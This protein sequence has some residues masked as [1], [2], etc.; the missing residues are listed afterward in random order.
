M[1]SKANLCLGRLI[2][3]EKREFMPLKVT[4]CY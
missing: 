2:Y 3:V 4:V 1:F